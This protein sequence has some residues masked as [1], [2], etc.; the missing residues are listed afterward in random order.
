MEPFKSFSKR[1]RERERARTGQPAIYIA[2]PLPEQFRNQV[3]LLLR[4]AIG[5][6]ER[7][8][9]SMMWTTNEA[10][11]TEIYLVAQRE[12]GKLTLIPRGFGMDPDEQ[13]EEFVQTAET[14][15]VLDLIEIAFCVIDLRMRSIFYMLRDRGQVAIAPDDAINQLNYRFREHDLGYQFAD[16]Q[17]M[18]V[19]SQYLHAEAVEPALTLLHVAGFAGPEEEFLSAHRH[20]RHREYT[21]A[22][23]D[24]NKAFESA[25]KAICEK[26]GWKYEKGAPAHKLI[27]MILDHDLIPRFVQDELS[28]LRNVLTGLPT[29]RNKA[30]GHGQGADPVDVPEH[31]AAYALHMAASNIVLLVQAHKAM[32]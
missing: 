22:I 29:L 5:K 18:E 19:S 10:V 24:A 28:G 26:R 9:S 3:V 27:G 31:L 21:S 14:E 7:H 32:M 6:F 23:V 25:M 13:C 30:G 15:P 2:G 20:F 12:L 8:S 4:D 17:L 16:G 11:W 1:Q